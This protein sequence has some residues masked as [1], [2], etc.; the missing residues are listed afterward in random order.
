PLLRL[1]S[2][3]F[4]D[5]A[6]ENIQLCKNLDE[7]NLA[8]TDRRKGRVNF[9]ASIAR[10]ARVI[11]RSRAKALDHGRRAK[12]QHLGILP[13]LAGGRWHSRRARNSGLLA[14]L[15]EGGF[16]ACGRDQS[17]SRGDHQRGWC[18]HQARSKEP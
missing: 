5:S 9:Y 18:Q 4:T 3:A 10:G 12:S 2:V 11:L 6:Q 1:W 13:P 16:V 17:Y 14:V 7:S 15:S 8:H